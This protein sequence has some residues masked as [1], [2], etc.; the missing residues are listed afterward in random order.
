V[1]PRSAFGSVI[2]G[3]TFTVAV[4]GQDGFSPGSART[5]TATPQE[6]NF[7]VCAVGGTA[8]ICKVDPSTVPLVMDTIAPAGVNQATELNPLNGPVVLQGVTVH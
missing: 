1:L 8:P 3:W 2:S 6:F 5:F 7:G 4:T